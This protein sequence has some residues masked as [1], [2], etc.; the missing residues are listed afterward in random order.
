MHKKIVQTKGALV[1]D[2]DFDSEEGMEAAVDTRK[3]LIKRH[4]KDYRFTED[5]AIEV[6]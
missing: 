3:F 4:L 2:D 6:H 1:N 5:S